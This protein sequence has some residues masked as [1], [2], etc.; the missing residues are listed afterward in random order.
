MNVFRT[1]V[2]HQIGPVVIDQLHRHVAEH[3]WMVREIG[4]ELTVDLLNGSGV[5]TAATFAEESD[6]TEVVDLSQRLGIAENDPTGEAVDIPTK[7]LIGIEAHI[8]GDPPANQRPH[9]L[10]HVS[11]KSAVADVEVGVG[12]PVVLVDTIGRQNN[13]FEAGRGCRHAGNTTPK[14]RGE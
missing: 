3:P 12:E 6:H 5:N 2:E 11:Q 1:G 8:S 14:T 7:Q 4:D 10:E 9:V 13:R